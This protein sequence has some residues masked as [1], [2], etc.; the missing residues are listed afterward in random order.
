MKHQEAAKL[1]GLSRPAA[2]RLWML[3][4]TWLYRA[5]RKGPE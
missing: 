4:R 2:D 1:L 3:A 5:L